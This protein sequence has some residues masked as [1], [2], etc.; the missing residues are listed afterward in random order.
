MRDPILLG[1][2]AVALMALLAPHVS[3]AVAAEA[4]FHGKTIAMIIGSEPG[5][6]SDAT[7]R[8]VAPFFKKYLPGNPNIVIRNMPGASGV[9]ALNYVVQQTKPD[10]LTMVVGASVQ[11]SPLTYRRANGIYDPRR[12]RYIGGIGRGGTV[13]LINK[14][15]EWRLTDKTAAPLFFGELDGTRSDELVAFWGM[16]YLGWNTKVV[17]GYRGTSDVMIA[18][19]RSEID[20]NATGN[21]YQVKNLIDTG[22]F[23][24]L[25]QSGI[26]ANGKF[27]SRPD[28]SGVPVFA[29]LMR[30]KLSDPVAK[31]AFDYW[32]SIAA[33]DKWIGLADNTPDDI[34]AAYRAAF[35]RIATDP[36][37]LDESRKISA[38]IAPMNHD[39]VILLVNQLAGA[40][41][42]VEDFIKA[43]Q[44]RHGLNVR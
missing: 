25:V 11:L 41:Q 40:N 10:G 15:Q 12:L 31:Q 20:M 33:L 18:L 32:Q 16:E 14:E 17:T 7:G 37:F 8:L 4:D 36:G 30:D 34:V 1:R 43:M 2:P 23:R 22:R 27:G 6:G 38:D 35:D 21:L 26:L 3:G 29:N 42:E 13:V 5:G 19:E 9:T 28:F 44:R 39:D 24:V